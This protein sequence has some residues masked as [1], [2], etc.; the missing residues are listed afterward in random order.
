MIPKSKNN[1]NDQDYVY[2]DTL[3]GDDVGE[4]LSFEKKCVSKHFKKKMPLLIEK[5]CVKGKHML[6]VNFSNFNIILMYDQ[7]NTVVQ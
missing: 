1:G 2:L 6:L 7:I 3:N 5:S 4:F